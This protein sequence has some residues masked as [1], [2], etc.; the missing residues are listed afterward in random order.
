LAF[1]PDSVQFAFSAGAEVALWDST[2]GE[3][4]N[5]WTDLPEAGTVQL[6]F[7][8]QRR[9]LTVR[10]EREPGAEHSRRWRVRHLSPDGT[11]T[12][13]AQQTEPLDWQT[14]GFALTPDARFFAA[15]NS[16]PGGDVAQW[17]LRLIE[18]LTGRELQ[19]HAHLHAGNTTAVMDASG[20]YLAFPA[21]DSQ[22]KVRTIPDWKLVHTLNGTPRMAP[23]GKTMAGRTADGA[24][25]TVVPAVD[26]PSI[27]LATVEVGLGTAGPVFSPKGDWVAWGSAHGLVGVA[28]WRAIQSGLSELSARNTSS[29]SPAR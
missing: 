27:P 22:A 1:H 7:D 24:G 25:F 9:L 2:S 13:L 16:I 20:R 21:G 29:S 8:G 3:T 10:N 26:A 18:T 12:V 5:H 23:D 17:E 28:D 11:S 15:W 14:Y 6:A 4:A 19:R